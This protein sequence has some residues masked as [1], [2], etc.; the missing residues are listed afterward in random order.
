MAGGMD[1]GPAKGGKKPLDVNINVVPFIDLMAVTISFLLLTA[2]WNQI[3]R[4]QVSQSGGAG[5]PSTEESKTIPVTLLV[6]ESEARLSIGAA[7]PQVFPLVR[8]GGPDGKVDLAGLGEALKAVKTQLPEQDII[9][10]QAE[11]AVLYDSLVNIIDECMG[12]GLRSVSV[13][14]AVG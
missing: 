7:P 3:G 10:V 9:T 1:L 5:S 6:S 2:A 4:L 8:T 11:D 12:A 14:A 13:Q